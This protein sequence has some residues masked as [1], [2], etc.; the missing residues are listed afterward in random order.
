MRH[1]NLFEELMEFQKDTNRFFED[2]YK[3][4]AM[5]EVAM[6]RWSSLG[7]SAEEE[8]YT[9]RQ[10]EQRASRIPVTSGRT[11]HEVPVETSHRSAL[12][13]QTT[14]QYS[15][16][17]AL[18]PGHSSRSAVT[19]TNRQALASSQSDAIDIRDDYD[20]VV[21]RVALPGIQEGDIDISVYGNKLYIQGKIQKTISL[22]NGIEAQGIRATYQ[23]GVLE[24]RLPKS[25]TSQRVDV[26]FRY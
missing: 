12:A 8:T 1:R 15:R 18:D 6:S 17:T 21:A 24:V 16:Q 11:Q 7:G 4:L 9:E 10:V 20:W 14:S 26:N 22:P 25:K 2:V 13:S 19:S 23:N 3:R 5:F